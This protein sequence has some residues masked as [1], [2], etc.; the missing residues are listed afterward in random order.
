MT[1]GVVTGCAAE[2][3]SGVAGVGPPC[4]T[5][6]ADATVMVESRFGAAATFEARRVA[7]GAAVVSAGCMAALTAAVP[8]TPTTVILSESHDRPPSALPRLDPGVVQAV[9]ADRHPRTALMGTINSLASRHSNEG[10]TYG[11]RA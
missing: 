10:T 9:E 4:C 2:S 11:T 8:T 6:V 1:T 5:T 3:A 7:A